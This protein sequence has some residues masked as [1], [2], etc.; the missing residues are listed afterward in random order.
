MGILYIVGTPIGNLEDLS[1]RARRVLNEVSTIASE[2][3][4]TT[5]KLLQRHAIHTHIVSYFEGNHKQRVPYLMQ[6]LVQGDVALV[7]EAGVPGIRDPG[8][9]LVRAALDEGHNV[10]PIPGPSAIT[11]ALSVSGLPAE[12]FLFLGFLPSKKTQRRRVL[13]EVSLEPRTLVLFETPHRLNESLEDLAHALGANRRVAACRELTKLHEEVYRGTISG[14]RS[15]FV[16]PRGEFTLVVEGTTD[17]GGMD[18]ARIEDIREDLRQ[19]K[20]SDM[21]VKEAMVWM[22]RQHGLSRRQVYRM[23]LDLDVQQRW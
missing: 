19:L 9:E 13:E 10:I 3:T 8:L 17:T 15:H 21:P 5:R 2:D 22:A 6:Q 7:S 14:A 12:E 16:S 1:L 18:E 4:R 11:T 20:R 23:W